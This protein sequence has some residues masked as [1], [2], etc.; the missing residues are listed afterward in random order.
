MKVVFVNWLENNYLSFDDDLR[1]AVLDFAIHVQT[2]GLKDLKGRNK[3]SAPPNPH[4]KKEHQHAKF[5]QKYC[6]W[7]YHLGVPCYVKQTNGDFTSE[8][9]LHYCHYNDV[10]VL[11]D[12]STHPPFVL[13]SVDKLTYD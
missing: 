1:N 6:L 10:I 5:A 8:Y 12:I 13:P 9:I 3:S 4:T 11:V 2:N 7:H